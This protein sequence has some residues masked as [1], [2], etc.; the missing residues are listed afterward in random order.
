RPPDGPRLRLHGVASDRWAA[1]VEPVRLLRCAVRPRHPGRHV[2]PAV[3]SHAAVPGVGRRGGDELGDRPAPARRRG[4]RVRVCAGE[5]VRGNR[6]AGGG[7]RV[8]ALGEV[9]DALAAR[10]AH[11]HRRAGVA[12]AGA[13]GART[14]HPRPPGLA[15]PSSGY[16]PPRMWELRGLFG[17]FWLAA[18]VAAP[19]VAG[20]RA[21]WWAWVFAGLLVFSLGGASLVEWMPGFRLF[22]A[23]AR[24]LLVAAFPLAVLAGTTT[25]ALI[26][27]N[28]AEE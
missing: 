8:H 24:M 26:R 3:R 27:S 7:G 28:W 16:D 19:V 5:R 23:P 25:D 9:A 6:R 21:R 20:G 12:A 10:R 17:V 14:R 13:A 11:G 22:R 18:A 15:G 1:S 2:L 4:V